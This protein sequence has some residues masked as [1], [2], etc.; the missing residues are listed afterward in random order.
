MVND[1]VESGVG[2]VE[3]FSKDV[4]VVDPTKVYEDTERMVMLT[5][6]V[7]STAVSLPS[8]KEV[9]SN[10]QRIPGIR[11]PNGNTEVVH[12]AID[13]TDQNSSL[14]KVE[15]LSNKGNEP[16]WTG[17]LKE[18]KEIQLTSPKEFARIMGY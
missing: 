11:T 10:R 13:I 1:S 12:D 6:D 16:V 4:G 7:D 8:G 9:N 15:I 2:V 17:T 14:I 5:Y 18:L 3:Q